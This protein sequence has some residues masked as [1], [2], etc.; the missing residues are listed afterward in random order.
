[1]TVTVPKKE[2]IRQLPN[3]TRAIFSQIIVRVKESFSRS[4]LHPLELLRINESFALVMITVLGAIIRFCLL[5]VSLNYPDSIHYLITAENI[6]RYGRLSWSG[7]PEFYPSVYPP[8]CSL[9]IVPFYLLFGMNENAAKYCIAFFGTMMIPGTYFLA[10]EFGLERKTRLLSAILIATNPLCWFYSLVVMSDVPSAFFVLISI[11]LMMRGVKTGRSSVICL[12]GLAAG[13]SFLIREL[14]LLV[15]FPLFFCLLLWR[16]KQPVR[17]LGE[18]FLSF[19][20]GLFPVISYKFYLY[21]R[22][23]VWSGYELWPGPLGHFSLENFLQNLHPFIYVVTSFSLTPPV[24]FQIQEWLFIPACGFLLAMVGLAIILIS[25]KR[26]LA[27]LL[28]SWIFPYLLFS[29]FYFHFVTRYLMPILPPLLLL[30]SYALLKAYESQVAV[31]GKVTKNLRFISLQ[32]FVTIFYLSVLLAVSV[33]SGYS[34]AWSVHTTPH[35]GTTIM[36]WIRDNT[37]DNSV[38]ITGFG[39]WATYYL[40]KTDRVLIDVFNAPNNT[41]KIRDYIENGRSVYLT[42]EPMTET[43]YTEEFQLLESEFAVVHTANIRGAGDIY[44]VYDRSYAFVEPFENVTLW[45][46]SGGNNVHHNF[47]SNGEVANL[48]CT[49]YYAVYETITDINASAYPFLE[50]RVRT[51]NLSFSTAKFAIDV[52]DNA[53]TGYTLFHETTIGG[54][55]KTFRAYL[56]GLFMN[57]KNLRYIRLWIIVKNPESGS[58]AVLW[59]W[60]CIYGPEYH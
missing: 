18:G 11:F 44:R 13:F 22:Y 43:Y 35:P 38:V 7:P 6:L 27:L 57:G 8:G 55:W 36:V 24:G 52:Y 16:K 32:K 58:G 47:A 54:V 2:L 56:K 21:S 33:F 9:L 1:M 10:K 39:E 20:V 5:S 30:I 31:T 50:V 14:N 46:Y 4:L 60:L 53:G 25:G 26:K 3:V 59:D 51:L 28:S 23:H 29:F 12:G 15:Y 48:T 34:V 49:N 45:S 42:R 37:P 17:S 41:M 19:I 40:G